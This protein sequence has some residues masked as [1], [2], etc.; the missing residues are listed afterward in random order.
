M[1]YDLEHDADEL[2]NLAVDDRD[3][4]ARVAALDALCEQM[5]RADDI[6]RMEPVSQ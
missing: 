4:A 2:T 3:P 6:T 5:L 1:L